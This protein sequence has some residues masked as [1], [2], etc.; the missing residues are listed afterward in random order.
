MK[1]E[2]TTQT[3]QADGAP[4][5][6][7][8]ELTKGGSLPASPEIEPHALTQL[9]NE[10]ICFFVSFV[11][12]FGLPKSV[13][14]IY[15]LLF[16]SARLLTMDEIATRLCISKGSTSQ[17]LSLLRELGAVTSAT[18]TVGRRELYCADLNVSRIVRHFF[19]N[20]LRNQL[21]KGQQHLQ[22]MLQ[23]ACGLEQTDEVDPEILT[24]LIS[25]IEALEKWHSR[26]RDSLPEIV[27]W[28]K[29]S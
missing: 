2:I 18:E 19:D 27:R 4:P 21:E 12:V 20:L 15:G 5:P 16:A 24:N 25:R 29:W 22:T 3:S 14:Q 9:E 28:L 10:T 1:D 6:S 26:G 8:G 7:G 23:L 11:Q 17:G 13:G